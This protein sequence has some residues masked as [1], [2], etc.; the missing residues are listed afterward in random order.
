MQKILRSNMFLFLSL[1]ILS[2][3]VIIA[4]YFDFYCHVVA[5]YFEWHV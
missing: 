2:S 5:V 1:P 3:D 4:V